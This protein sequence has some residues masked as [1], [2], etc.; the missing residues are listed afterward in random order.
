MQNPYIR[1]GIVWK[2]LIRG[3]ATRSRYEYEVNILAGSMLAWA[4]E[5][6]M[7]GEKRSGTK[8]NTAA[9][10]M[11]FRDRAPLVSSATLSS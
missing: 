5:N 10:I 7:K 2:M 8:A 9:L 4:M 11:S 6:V 3:F 1:E